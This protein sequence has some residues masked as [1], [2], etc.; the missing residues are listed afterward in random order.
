MHAKLIF[1]DIDGTLAMPGYSP[2]KAVT[3]AIRAARKAGHKVFISTGRVKQDVPEAIHSIGFDGGIYSAGGYIEADGN[4][5]FHQVMQPEMIHRIAAAL[6]CEGM[7]Y[8][9]ESPEGNFKGRNQTSSL[10]HTD[11]SNAASE[12]RRFVLQNFL[13]EGGKTADHYTDEPVY[14]ITFLSP[15]SDS[16]DRLQEQIGHLAKIVRFDNLSGD[17]P[18]ICGEI[19]D[20]SINKGAALQK[21]CSH[22]DMTCSECIAFGDSMNDAEILET[23]GLGIAMGNSEPVILEIADMVCDSCEN[24]GVA[25]ALAKLQLF[26]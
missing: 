4:V 24:D 1:F 7:C 9:L 26:P 2:S 10:L 20:F 8:C 3:E 13:G 15:D 23:A 18:F 22:Y 6:C 19:S 14:K 25:K 5:L 17:F 11:L 21:I 12:L 16:I